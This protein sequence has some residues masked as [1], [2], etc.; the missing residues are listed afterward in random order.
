[1]KKQV[2]ETKTEAELY[3]QYRDRETDGKIAC[4][5]RLYD[6]DETELEE[7]I[8]LLQKQLDTEQIVSERIRRFVEKKTATVIDLA[9]NQEKIKDKKI[10]GLEKDKDEIIRKKEDDEKEITNKH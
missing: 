5:Q 8:R 2:N 7:K 9:D 10:E 6:K 4:Q 1:M 3:V